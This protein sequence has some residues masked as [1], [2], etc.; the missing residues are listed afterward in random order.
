LTIQEFDV[1]M[2]WRIAKTVT[3]IMA[4]PKNVHILGRNVICTTAASMNPLAAQL[5]ARVKQFAVRVVKFVGALPSGVPTREIGSQLLKAGTSESA[6]Y[7]A[8]CRARSRKEFIAKL[9][10]VVEEADETEHWLD[11]IKQG[12]LA[13][14]PELEWLIGEAGELRAIFRASL[15]TARTNYERDTPHRARNPKSLNP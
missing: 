1:T 7:H 6:N 12:A 9:G 4:S 2:V 11:V 5:R 8:A 10:T 14:G 15:E 3:C 13:A